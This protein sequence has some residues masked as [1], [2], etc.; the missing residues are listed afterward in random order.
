MLAKATN[1]SKIQKAANLMEGALDLVSASCNKV[2]LNYVKCIIVYTHI[3]V[4]VYR[5]D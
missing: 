3:T 5:L 4:E 1:S 2:R